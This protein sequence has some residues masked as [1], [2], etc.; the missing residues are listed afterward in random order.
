[1]KSR[2]IAG[3]LAFKSGLN[4]PW[5][6]CGNDWGSS[7]DRALFERSF[8][9]YRASGAD[10]VRIWIHFDGTKNLKLWDNSGNFKTLPSNFYDDAKHTF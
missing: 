5:G 6:N 7:Y 9:K 3:A 8:S 4:M 2:I 10:S 1:M